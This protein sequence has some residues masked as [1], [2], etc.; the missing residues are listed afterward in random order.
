MRF[1]S[2]ACTNAKSLCQT[3]WLHFKADCGC[4]GT[5]RECC[6]VLLHLEKLLSASVWISQMSGAQ[7]WI[8]LDVEPKSPAFTSHAVNEAHPLRPI[9]FEDSNVKMCAYVPLCGLQTLACIDVMTTG[10]M[11]NRLISNPLAILGTMEF[12]RLWPAHP[13]LKSLHS[14]LFLLA[15]AVNCHN[16]TLCASDTQL[17]HPCLAC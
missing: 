13:L 10:S 17:W 15:F 8:D 9:E 16:F 1:L 5:Q 6:C 3:L 11:L 7:E 12:N 14:Y 2:C 4:K